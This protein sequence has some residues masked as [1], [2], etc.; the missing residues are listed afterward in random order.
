[1]DLLVKS[2]EKGELFVQRTGSGDSWA[3]LQLNGS[4]EEKPTAARWCLL[5]DLG[6]CASFAIMKQKEGP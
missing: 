4:S 3:C 6:R 2:N 1:M 5:R